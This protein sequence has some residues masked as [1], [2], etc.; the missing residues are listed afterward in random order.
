MLRMADGTKAPVPMPTICS[1]VFVAGIASPARVQRGLVAGTTSK[2]LRVLFLL[3]EAEHPQTALPIKSVF[4]ASAL[5]VAAVFGFFPYD[6]KGSL[7]ST[8]HMFR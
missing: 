1:S 6:A 4:F 3:D 8:C 7:L 2:H 5:L